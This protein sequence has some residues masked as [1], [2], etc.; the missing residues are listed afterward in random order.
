MSKK[1]DLQLV[2]STLSLIQ[3]KDKWNIYNLAHKLN[4][5]EKNKIFFIHLNHTNPLLNNDS[6]EYNFVLRKGYNIAKEGM[7]LEL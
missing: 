7:K 4:I 6:V 5:E 3:N 2:M 1:I